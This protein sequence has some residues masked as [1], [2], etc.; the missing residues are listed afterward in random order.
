M[1]PKRV[2][3]GFDFRVTPTSLPEGVPQDQLLVPSLRSPVSADPNV[4]LEPA[5]VESLMQDV[6]T[7]FINPL[8]LAKSVEVLAD[9]VRVRGFSISDALPVCLTTWDTNVLALIARFGSGYFEY[10]AAE[11]ELLSSGWQ[12]LGFDAVDLDGLISGLKGCGYIEPNW[13]RLRERFGSSL[14]EIGLFNTFESAS[15]FAEVRG[16]EIRAHAPFVPVGI[17]TRSKTSE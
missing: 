17:L 16:L 15:R 9:A 8:H 14:N 3:I 11:E 4:W 12:H 5:S 13:S 2:S 1:H 10:Q 6:T 7:Q